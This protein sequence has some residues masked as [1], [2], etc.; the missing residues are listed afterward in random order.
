MQSEANLPV[1]E[2]RQ[3]WRREVRQSADAKERQADR[4]GEVS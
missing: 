4:R 1:P 2:I 3:S